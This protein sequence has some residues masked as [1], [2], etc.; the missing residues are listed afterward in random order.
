M[1]ELSTPPI[2]EPILADDRRQPRAQAAPRHLEKRPRAPDR[3]VESSER[4]ELAENGE[5][6]H[7]VDI[8]V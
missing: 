4:E 6:E 1:E 5:P 7:N 2:L 3:E 8:S